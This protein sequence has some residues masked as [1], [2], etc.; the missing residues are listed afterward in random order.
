MSATKGEIKQVAGYDALGQGRCQRRRC[1]TQQST[2]GGEKGESG[3]R[4]TTTMATGDNNG[5]GNGAT[6]DGTTGYDKDDD[7]DGNHDNEGD[8]NDDGDDDGGGRR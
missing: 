3:K 1:N 8:N 4:R 2:N 5:D 7:G 6:G